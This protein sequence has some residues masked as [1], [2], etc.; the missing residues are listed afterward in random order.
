MF[1]N[2]FENLDKSNRCFDKINRHDFDI[3]YKSDNFVNKKKFENCY[4]N[5]SK[6]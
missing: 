4:D 2:F 6:F 3:D 1:I 5:R